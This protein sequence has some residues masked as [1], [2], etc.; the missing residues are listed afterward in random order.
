MFARKKAIGHF[1]ALLI[2]VK[3]VPISLMMRSLRVPSIN[4]GLKSAIS[5]P[6][7]VF[8]KF[9]SAISTS[10]EWKKINLRAFP[11]Q[12]S[13]EYI[14]FAPLPSTTFQLS[15]VHFSV[16]SQLISHRQP[17]RHWLCQS[18]VVTWWI[19]NFYRDFRCCLNDQV[20]IIN[21]KSII[22]LGTSEIVKHFF[23]SS[24]SLFTSLSGTSVLND[25]FS[26]SSIIRLL[27]FPV[28]VVNLWSKHQLIEKRIFTCPYFVRY[29]PLNNWS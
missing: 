18:N 20:H 7:L 24:A 16:R 12:G 8:P 21:L 19:D 25:S 26:L 3:H 11:F 29:F 23:K 27:T 10:S 15:P 2:Y 17:N 5:R 1:F 28:R 14:K 13:G 9:Q 4:C 6:P 22:F